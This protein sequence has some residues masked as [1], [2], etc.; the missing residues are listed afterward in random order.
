MT[1]ITFE[2]PDNLRL[3]VTRTG[4]SFTAY[5]PDLSAHILFV[6]PLQAGHKLLEAFEL[7]FLDAGLQVAGEFGANNSF[8]VSEW[9]T[10]PLDH[11][12]QSQG[13]NDGNTI[14]SR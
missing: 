13:V 12:M 7:D 1:I 8:I 5:L 10:L 4:A 9:R 14:R 11:F 2:L 6:F 3:R